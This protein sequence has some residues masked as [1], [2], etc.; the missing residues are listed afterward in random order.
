VELAH[1]TAAVSWRVAGMFFALGILT[2][3]PFQTEFLWAHDSVLYARAIERF[4]PLD[5]RPQAP[6]YLYYVLL[7]RAIYW[8]VGDPNRAM[9]IVSLFAGAGAVALLYLLAARLYDERTARAS[10]AFLLT[11]VTFWAYG[12]VAYPY[13]LLAALS[14]GCALLFWLALRA[15]SGSGPRLALATAAY[16][17]A[18]GFR[19]DLAVFLAPLWLMTAIATPL[20]WSLA[21][22]LFGVLLV[23]GWFFASAAMDGGVNTLLEA[24]RV[25]GQFVDDRYSVFGDLGLRALYGNVYELTRYLGRGL[26]F[27]AALLVA[28]P[29]SVGARRIE[30]S[31]RR[32]LAFLLLWTLTPLAIYIPIHVGEYGY[33]FSMLPGLCIIAA[34]GAIALARGARMPRLLPWAVATVALANAAVFLTGDAPLSARFIVRQD[35]GIGE[36]IERLNQADLAGAT[37]L[38]AYEGLVVEYYLRDDP[39]LGA[40]HV[41]FSYDPALPRRE[42]PFSTRLCNP[43]GDA[44][45]DR[46]PVLVVWDDTIRLSG[47]GWE[48]ITMRH[49]AKM[50]V[51]RNVDNVRLVIDGLSVE[52]VR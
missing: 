39:R 42:V 2:R 10:G 52:I 49:G 8:V 7:I 29:L 20:L 50:R 30:L 1:T 18:I 5:Q 32:R 25:Q 21:C 11:A 44:C 19:T 27:L 28:V 43:V 4:D 34:R 33:V 15:E 48:T 31:D 12:G 3:I 16:G 45:R 23:V 9:T 41:L 37:I 6:G 51:A 47:S 26:Y 46:D 14:I 35:R 38:S 36:R 22:A 40:Q 24:M 17:I 13:T